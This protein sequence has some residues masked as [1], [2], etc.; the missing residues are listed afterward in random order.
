MGKFVNAA[1]KASSEIEML[2]SI[3]YDLNSAISDI[4]DNSINAIR[5][6]RPKKP[7]IRI[8]LL[9]NT[10]NP[11]VS[12]LDNGIGMEKLELQD[13][14]RIGCKN[15]NDERDFGDLGRFG[16]GL[17]TASFSQARILSVLSKRSD[18]ISGAKFDKKRITEKDSWD[19]EV[20][21][22]NDIRTYGE[23][24]KLEKLE[25]GTLVIWQNLSRYNP[26]D[27]SHQDNEKKLNSDIVDLKKHLSHF[28]HRFMSGKNKISFYVN[29]D[30]LKPYNPFLEGEDGYQEGDEEKHRVSGGQLHF[31]YHIIPH[32]SKMTQTQLDNLGGQQEVMSKQGLYV[33]RSDRL[34]IEGKWMGINPK[35]VSHG[36]VRIEVNIP[37]SLD[38][39]W[40]IDVKKSTLELPEQVKKLLK[41][42][43]N[44]PKK[45]S[46]GETEFTGNREKANN[47]WMINDDPRENLI[48]YEISTENKEIK[49]LTRKLDKKSLSALNKY[50]HKLTNNLPINHIT[51]NVNNRPKDI[52]QESIDSSLL[53]E[54]LIEIWTSSK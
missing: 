44:V 3:G 20:L 34:I 30:L 23:L 41:R 52:E 31:K 32:V 50:L 6:K 51:N 28:F 48:T 9:P 39:A 37:T 11:S 13:S 54:K 43:S 53:E 24:G 17:K 27:S 36:L 5:T 1:P 40:S 33:Y 14:M 29:G 46:K 22:Q 47:Y 4:V 49:N 45:K 19:L 7:F 42:F 2:S 25:S 26:E 38:K 21:D 12:I 18:G 35:T 10:D 15:P 16:S 8:N